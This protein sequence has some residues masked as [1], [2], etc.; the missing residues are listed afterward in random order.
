VCVAVAGL[1]GGLFMWWLGIYSNPS[2]ADRIGRSWVLL[3]LA[4]V[5]LAALGR[6]VAQPWALLLAT[7]ALA[8]DVASGSLLA[9]V[10]LF[11]DIVYAAARYGPPRLARLLLPISAAVTVAVTFGLL[12][13]FRTPQML[14]VGAVVATVT[15]M[16]A[17]TGVVIRN[18]RDAA[19]AERLRAEQTALLAEMDRVQAVTA[20]RARMARELHDVVA[21][22]LSAI[23][24]HSTAAL[25]LSGPAA[26]P[27]KGSEK[28]SEQD[29][30]ADPA[31]DSATDPAAG[32]GAADEAR[33]DGGRTALDDPLPSTAA[34][35]REALTVIRENSVQGLAEMRRLIAL[36]RDSADGPAAGGAPGTPGGR[37]STPYAASPAASPPAPSPTLDALDALVARAR[38]GAGDTGLH[39]TL[40]DERDRNG[41][42]VPLPAPVELAAYR[43]VQEAV[44]NALKHAAPGPVHIQLRPGGAESGDRKPGPGEPAAREAAPREPAV[45]EAAVRESAIRE[46]AGGAADP[47]LTVLVTSPLPDPAARRTGTRSPGTDPDADGGGRPRAPGSGT[48]LIGMRER[49]ELL[50]GTLYAGPVTGD[51]GTRRWEVR[52][53]LPTGERTTR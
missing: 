13:A 19:S 12:A 41:T 40:H 5:C 15:V 32:G 16:P 1:L 14:P 28:G 23:A 53:E 43:V 8:G 34:A 3:P 17:W 44:T 4:A 20:E 37:D 46:G 36:L 18:H 50:G 33:E 48:G 11:T 10:V 6:R 42:P 25:S 21:N 35:T 2:Y 31:T 9:T 51:H 38:A 29:P 52:A 47:P 30:A 49:V 7:A 24:V 27:E 26:D 45:R 39:F 22:H